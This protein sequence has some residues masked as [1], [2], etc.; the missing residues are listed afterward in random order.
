MDIQI[1]TKAILVNYEGKILVLKRSE[2]A[3]RRPSQWDIPGGHADEGEYMA[4]AAARVTLEET[5]ITI[6]SQEIK[7]VYSLTES[8]EDR[9]STTWLFFMAKTNHTDVELSNEHTD[10]EWVDPEEAIN[11]IEYDRQN[12][13][14]QYV[15]QHGLLKY[16]P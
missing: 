4:E 8:P 7:L 15:H 1:V 6:D 16:A 14:L 9:N 3:V 13:A 2:S 11:R 12:R 5:G 10:Y